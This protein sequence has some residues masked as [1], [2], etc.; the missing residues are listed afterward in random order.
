MKLLLIG[1]NSKYIHTNLAVRYLKAACN[2]ENIEA[3]IKEYTINDNM[4]DI[5]GDI[6]ARRAEVYAFSVY[7]WN[8]EETFRLVRDI[9]KIR[10]EATIILGGPEV[11]F[12]S[13]KALEE[14]GADII[15]RGEG[16]EIFSQLAGRLVGRK[17]GDS[18][19]DM[20]KDIQ[21]LTLKSGLQTPD[22][23]AMTLDSAGFPYSL[24]DLE[25][26]KDRIIYYESSR[27]CPFSCSYCMS[28]I[29]RRLR[30]RSLDQVKRELLFFIE[31]EV[32]QVKFVDR[33]FNCDSKRCREIISFIIENNKCTNFHFEIAGDLLDDE[34]I[35]LLAKAQPGL[36]QLE[37]GVQSVN[38]KTLKEINRKT[39]IG[40]IRS[41]VFKLRTAGNLHLHLDLIAGLPWEDMNSFAFSFDEVIGMKPHALQVGFLKIL[42][43]TPISAKTKEHGIIFRDYPTYQILYNK[44]ISYEEM[45]ILSDVEHMVEKYYNSGH[46]NFTM[47]MISDHTD[48]QMFDFFKDLAGFWT[49]KGYH[50]TGV[51]KDNLYRILR[52]FL[53]ASEYENEMVEDLLKMD[54]LTTNK[55][56]LPAFFEHE[57]PGK[58]AVFEMLKDSEFIARYLPH[59]AGA[60]PKDLFKKI[61]LETFMK[62]R[63]GGKLA[64]FYKR[65]D[66]NFDLDTLNEM[67]W[68]D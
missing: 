43:G 39:D 17:T 2:M 58:E 41:N 8:V 4:E 29:D 27:G 18:L 1:I 48:G 54:Y 33:T 56:P 23:E 36:I 26:L 34:T 68:I 42:K 38:Q 67:A 25:T 64:I 31:N 20:L 60:S 22:A 12:E 30:L 44:Y 62:K 3:E 11:S 53:M 9:K 32:R 7:I 63:T 24:Q 19:D 21:G 66:T 55:W 16:E 59:L 65:L 47:E 10:P 15:L 40:K 61:H 57:A 13:E 14:S 46:F 6:M 45:C 52:E 37:I 49:L 5:L 35:A 28:A 51:S 50:S